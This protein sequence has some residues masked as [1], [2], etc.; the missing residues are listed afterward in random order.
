MMED[1]RA[2]ERHSQVEPQLQEQGPGIQSALSHW[3]ELGAHTHFE[4]G[5]EGFWYVGLRMRFEF[6][7]FK[8]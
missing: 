5:S 3:T 2:T 8:S 4:L 7:V 6:L 1:G